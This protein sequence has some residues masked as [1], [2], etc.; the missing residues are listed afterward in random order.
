MLSASE[1]VERVSY[2]CISGSREK[3]DAYVRLPP[4]LMHGRGRQRGLCGEPQRHRVH[5]QVEAYAVWIAAGRLFKVGLNC[6]MK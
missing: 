5:A 2:T 3:T 1:D 6:E 4:D